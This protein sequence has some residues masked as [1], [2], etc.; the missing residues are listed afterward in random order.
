MYQ[1]HFAPHDIKVKE[2]G[3]GITR[4]EK[5][6][7][8]GISFKIVPNIPIADGIEAV[9]TA[10]GRF[11]IDTVNCKDLIKALERCRQEKIK[12]AS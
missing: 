2:L 6:R 7:Q 5:A 11:W 1:S 12:T 8:L 4:L 10:F 9:R 3:T